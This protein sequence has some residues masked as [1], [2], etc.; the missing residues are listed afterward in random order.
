M[1]VAANSAADHYADLVVEGNQATLLL[2]GAWTVA[3]LPEEERARRVKMPDGIETLVID[4]AALKDVDTSGAWLIVQY[5]RNTR[6]DKQHVQWR[7]FGETASKII[8]LV[9]QIKHLPTPGDP[10]GAVYRTFMTLGRF[11]GTVRREGAALVAFFGQLCAVFAHTLVHPERLRMKSVFYHVNEICIR[12]TPIIA[13]MSFL[14]SIVLGYQGANQLKTFG[15]TIFTIDLVSVSMLREMGV[16]IT[17]I[18]VAGRSSSAFAAQIGVMR[19]NDEVAALRTIGLDPFEM[20]ILPRM[21][22]IVIALPLLTFLADLSGLLGAFL[23]SSALLHMSPLQ[24][25]ERLHEAVNA[26]TFYVGLGKAPIFAILIGLVGCEQ[27]M[28]VRN[29]ATELGIRTTKAVV[30][31]IFLVILADAL[32]SVFFTLMG[33]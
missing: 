18:L 31:S 25:M 9:E 23:M 8:A 26:H 5:V 28:Q 24:F 2:S 32:F 21:I 13:L 4:G 15:A 11:T 19:M 20:L 27:G 12:A 17:S 30:Q 33:I 22:A 29:S 14:I 10:H 6:L 1:S 7:G 16:L 3:H